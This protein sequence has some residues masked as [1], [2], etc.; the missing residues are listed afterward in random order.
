MTLGELVAAV[1]GLQAIGDYAVPSTIASYAL[2]KAKV[3]AAAELETLEATRVALCEAHAIKDDTGAPVR[4]DGQYQFADLAAF[5]A[6][7]QKL[8][9]EHVTLH[10]VRAVTV[11]ELEGASRVIPQVGGPPAVVRGIPSD[12]LFALGPFVAD[13]SESG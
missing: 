7:W 9:A 4:V 12:V 3:K 11:A 10:D 6:D 1:P 13:P 5:E 2:R 8:L